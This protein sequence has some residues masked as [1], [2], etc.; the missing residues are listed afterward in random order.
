MKN[1]WIE[2]SRCSGNPQKTKRWRNPSILVQKLLKSVQGARRTTSHHNQRNQLKI[3]ESR[4]HDV[5]ETSKNKKFEK[6]PEFRFK[7]D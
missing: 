1:R 4:D 2:G 5:P 7:N 6:K 3:D